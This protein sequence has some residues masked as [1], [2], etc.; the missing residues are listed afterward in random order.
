MRK[1]LVASNTINWQDLDLKNDHLLHGD[2][3]DQNVFFDERGYVSSVFD[4]EKT[5]YS[6]R[7]FELIRSMM[8]NF[9]SNDFNVSNINKAKLYLHSYLNIY[10]ASREELRTGFRLYYLRT[11]HSAWVQK[12]HYLK[13]NYRVDQFLH[14]HYQNIKYLSEHFQEVE[15]D[16]ID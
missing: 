5:I 10:P 11:I 8:K 15:N 9:F 4:F 6:P 3:Y 14:N 7:S 16:L 2:Y 13:K 12:E 1:S